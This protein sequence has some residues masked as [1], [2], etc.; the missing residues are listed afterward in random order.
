MSPQVAARS[1]ARGRRPSRQSEGVVVLHDSRH[2]VGNEQALL[3]QVE[4]IYVGADPA[5]DVFPSMGPE[6]FDVTVRGKRVGRLGRS[7]ERLQR[8]HNASLRRGS[9]ADRTVIGA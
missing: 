3:A 9:D 4:R 2:E 1:D 5:E 6:E 8:E 7:S